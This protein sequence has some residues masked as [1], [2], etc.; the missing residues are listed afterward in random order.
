MGIWRESESLARD[1][2][3]SAAFDYLRYS[4]LGL[5]YAIGLVIFVLAGRYADSEW[6]WSPWGTLIGAVFGFTAS[7][8][9]LYR[10][11][12]SKRSE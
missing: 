9:W 11:I 8:T 1:R 5:Q 7:T 12:Y 3:R 10:Q 2:T 4:A 6:G